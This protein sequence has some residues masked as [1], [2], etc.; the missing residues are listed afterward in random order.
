MLNTDTCFLLSP[1]DQ[2]KDPLLV[3][4]PILLYIVYLA[5]NSLGVVSTDK[6]ALAVQKQSLTPLNYQHPAY[7]EVVLLYMIIVNIT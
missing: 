2:V 4:F 6:M 3:G 1:D 7:L 5:L